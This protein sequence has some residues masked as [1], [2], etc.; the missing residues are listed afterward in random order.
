MK[1]WTKSV[2]FVQGIVGSSGRESV[3]KTLH[4]SHY[5]PINMLDP[6]LC[7]G[8]IHVDYILYNVHSV[9][10]PCFIVSTAVLTIHQKWAPQDFSRGIS[11][12]PNINVW[13]FSCHVLLCTVWSLEPSHWAVLPGHQ[14]ANTGIYCILCILPVCSWPRMTS[15]L[16]QLPYSICRMYPSMFSMYGSLAVS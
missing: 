6:K 7:T 12:K 3:H 16:A 14:L 1:I 4:S 15:S 9:Q 2:E 10:C 11:A 5:Q 8:K 13:E